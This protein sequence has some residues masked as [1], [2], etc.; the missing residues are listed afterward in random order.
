[1]CPP[2][3]SYHAAMPLTPINELMAAAR[4]G[5]YAVGYFE[6]WDIASLQGVV[7]A[8][9][10][11]HAPVI[12]GFNGEFLTHQVRRVS[13]R[14]EWYGALGRVAAES[15]TVPCGFIFNECSDHDVVR[16]AVTCGFNLVM[17]VRGD[18]SESQHVQSTRQ[19]VQYAHEHG[20]AIESEIGELPFGA[21][22]QVD[23]SGSVT[24]G[25]QAAQFVRDTGVDL[26]GV[27]VGNVHLLV[28][29]RRELDSARLAAIA[30]CVD[31]PLVLHGGTG[32][33]HDSLREA[34]ALGI[35]KVNYG[36][37]LKQRFLAAAT[38][39][40]VSARLNPHETLGEGGEHD[41]LVAGRVALRDVVTEKMQVLGC[42]GR[43]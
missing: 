24:D 8:A 21:S 11:S 30:Q 6:A 40:M 7:D 28:K 18:M 22:G 34:V 25:E 29:G 39:R 4:R 36:T 5:K 3:F 41:A 32:I 12:I 31:I 42:V 9:E 15:A 10:Q 33:D 1:M 26:L 13:E 23:D 43:C 2:L 14:I 19:I 27:S 17:P 16:H 35:A 37:I 38:P 20:V